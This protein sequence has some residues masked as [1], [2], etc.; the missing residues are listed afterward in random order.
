MM[1]LNNAALWKRGPLAAAFCYPSASGAGIKLFNSHSERHADQY[2][3]VRSRNGQP[4][5]DV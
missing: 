2:H 3:W 4:G 1:C 5:L